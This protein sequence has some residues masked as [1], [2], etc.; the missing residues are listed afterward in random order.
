MNTLYGSK[1][2]LYVINFALICIVIILSIISASIY[3]FAPVINDSELSGV[4]DIR[5][6]GILP[7]IKS[8]DV[9]PSEENK[10]REGDYNIIS[11]K[12]AFSPQ[13]KEWVVK[14]AI[15]KPIGS[16]KKRISKKKSL[17]GKPKKIVLHGIVIAGD[18]KKALIKNPMTGVSKKKTLY[19]EEGE[20]V[21]GYVVTSIE[22]D[23]IRLDWQGE[24]IIVKL[25]AGVEGSGQQKEKKKVS[26]GKHKKPRIKNLHAREDTTERHEKDNNP[27]EEMGEPIPPELSMMEQESEK[28][29][30]PLE[31][32]GEPT[33]PELSM[34]EQESEKDNNPLEEMGELTQPK[35]LMMEQE[36]KPK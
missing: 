3:F 21:E 18:V 29:N 27:L 19:V 14:V 6:D 13:R 26:S 22:S 17:S 9:N 1:Y 15:P 25:Y 2:L 8:I 5:E 4:A 34:M 33:P 36:S 7:D 16:V 28:D 35:L 11:A 32:M 24:E 12:N 30:N 20:E 23:Q 10:L 31:E